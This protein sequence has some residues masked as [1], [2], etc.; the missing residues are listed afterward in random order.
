MRRYLIPALLVLAA[1]ALPA[2]AQDAVPNPLGAN[3]QALNTALGNVRNSIMMLANE[4]QAL[5]QQLTA[6]RDKCGDKCQAAPAP[7]AKTAPPATAAPAFHPSPK[8]PD[9]PL[10]KKSPDS[11]PK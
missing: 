10:A 9:T 6:L 4:N 1:S 5:Q 7:E 8:A 2:A 3:W 11:K